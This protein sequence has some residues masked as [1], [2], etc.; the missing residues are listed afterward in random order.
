MSRLQR[1]CCFT[2]AAML[3][4]TARTQA[5]D[6]VIRACDGPIG[7]RIID[8]TTNCLPFERLLTWPVA[9][10]AGPQGPR[11]PQG[12]AGSRGSVGPQGLQGVAGLPGPRGVTGPQGPQGVAGA[13]GPVGPAGAPGSTGL[14]GSGPCRTPGSA[15]THVRSARLGRSTRRHVDVFRSERRHDHGRQDH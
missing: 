14:T 7:M 4:A 1:I 15:W 3:G 8:S 12:P 13:P 6:Q 9:A 2:M 11:G 10:K 5:A